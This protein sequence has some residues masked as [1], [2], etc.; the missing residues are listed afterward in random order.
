MVDFPDFFS[1]HLAREFNLWCMGAIRRCATLHR[2]WNERSSTKRGL[3]ELAF[4]GKL[5]ATVTDIGGMMSCRDRLPG[6]RFA[7]YHWNRVGNQSIKICTGSLCPPKMP[8]PKSES[9]FLMRGSADTQASFADAVNVDAF[10]LTNSCK[11]SDPCPANVST[12]SDIR[13]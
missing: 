13:S 6:I 9:D 11:R 2:K 10:F 7:G 3:W 8:S 4:G 1:E 12:S 5:D